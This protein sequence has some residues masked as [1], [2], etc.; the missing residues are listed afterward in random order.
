MNTVELSIPILGNKFQDY[1]KDIA[2]DSYTWGGAI[3]PLNV[4]YF[5]FHHSVTA[6]TALKDGNWKAECDKIA[7]LHLARGWGGI[8]YRFVIC[9]D[10]TVAYV[11]DLSHWG[12]AVGGNNDKIFSACLVGDFTKVLPTA[13]Q[14]HSAYLLAKFFIEQM[15]QYP[16]IDSWDDIIGHKDAYELL[17]LVGSEPT[18]CPSPVWRGSG[19]T[20]RNRILQDHFDGYPNPQPTWGL[21]APTPPPAPPAPPAPTPE[22]VPQ[23]EPTPQPTPAPVPPIEDKHVKALKDILEIL[24]GVGIT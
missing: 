7:Q 24:K 9:S 19:D 15:P 12:S 16:K 2:G 18:T 21:P 17:H 8:G 6:Q 23:P 5:A 1:R 3:N 13:A 10:G 20:L 4:Q 11:G 22:P 14:V